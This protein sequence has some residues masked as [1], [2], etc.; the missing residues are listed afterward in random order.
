MNKRL[1]NLD[2]KKEQCYLP[3][4]DANDGMRWLW[5]KMTMGLLAIIEEV[6]S[7]TIEKNCCKFK[8]I[9]KWNL[10]VSLET[11][12]MWCFSG[13]CPVKGCFTE[14]VKWDGMW[15]FAGM[16]VLRGHVIFGKSINGS[17]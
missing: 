14:A 3:V 1:H 10:V 7:E 17:S 13:S 6:V 5:W 2:V 11:Q 8:C 16:V 4:M 15:C 9:L 12:V